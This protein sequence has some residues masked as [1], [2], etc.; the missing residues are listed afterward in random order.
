MDI[1]LWMWL[2][3]LLLLLLLL[4]DVIV[5]GYAFNMR[6]VFWYFAWKLPSLP[7]PLLH[8]T[9]T[10]FALQHGLN[11]NKSH[12][13][14]HTI[15]HLF[16]FTWSVIMHE[17]VV[18]FR[19]H[20]WIR[21]VCAAIVACFL[22]GGVCVCVYVYCIHIARTILKKKSKNL[23]HIYTVTTILFGFCVACIDFLRSSH[24]HTKTQKRDGK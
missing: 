3:V 8:S 16:H 5:K 23:I 19:M 4:L 1:F 9:H 2:F 12:L 10:C 22:G 6:V 17:K 7:T 21:L 11:W 18:W 15:G 13:N 14:V 24:A 20:D